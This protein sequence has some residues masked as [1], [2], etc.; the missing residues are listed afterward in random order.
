MTKL[1]GSVSCFSPR[2][3]LAPP[4]HPYRDASS[5]WWAFD[6]PHNTLLNAVPGQTR[7]GWDA[8][9][10]LART[11]HHGPQPILPLILPPSLFLCLFFLVPQNCYAKLS[12]PRCGGSSSSTDV[13]ETQC[14]V[15]E[16]HVGLIWEQP[17]AWL[18]PHLG[19]V[20]H[21]W[22]IIW[23]LILSQTAADRDAD[24]S[25]TTRNWSIQNH[26]GRRV[27]DL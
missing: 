14:S 27:L 12:R 20:L 1:L 10:F 3:A 15:R 18:L 2:R 13:S 24:S 16:R 22:R 9:S 26:P 5:P 11:R 19:P 21:L 6:R 25:P 4:Q 17:G 8:G 23:S 7:S